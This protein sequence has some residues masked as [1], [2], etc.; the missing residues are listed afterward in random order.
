MDRTTVQDMTGSTL[1]FQQNANSRIGVTNSL[2]PADRR[3]MT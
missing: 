1:S 2:P 3:A